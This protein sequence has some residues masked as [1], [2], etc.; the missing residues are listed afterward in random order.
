MNFAGVVNEA[1]LTVAGDFPIE[2]EGHQKANNR[3]G[4]NWI[5]L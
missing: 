1:T 2:G 5:N 3:P 4:Y